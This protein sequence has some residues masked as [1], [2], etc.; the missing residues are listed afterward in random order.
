MDHSKKV[1][2][3][4]NQIAS[5]Y[6]DEYF[7]DMSDVSLLDAF[8]S[9]LPKKSFIVDVGCGPGNNTKY[10][11]DA[12]YKVEGIDFSDAMIK[13]AEQKV[14]DASFKIMDM[15]DMLYK[16]KSVDGLVALYSLIHI[17]SKE[18]P[19]TLQE[20]NRVLKTGGYVFIIVQKGKSDQ[21]LPEPLLKSEKTFVNFFSQERLADS[22][23]NSGFTMVTMDELPLQDAEGLSDHIICAIAKKK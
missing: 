21:T 18:I 20:F 12:G 15:R 1:Q 16:D 13:V 19:T 10:M 5:K 3:T 17:H 4:Y 23:T 22:L 7:H 9:Y 2:D 14:P 6:A 8:L 11:M